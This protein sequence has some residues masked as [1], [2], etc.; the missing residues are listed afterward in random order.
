MDKEKKGSS[1]GAVGA[2]MAAGGFLGANIGIAGFFGAI[3]GA[4]PLALLGGYVGHRLYKA[5]TSEPENDTLGKPAE[6]DAA[7]IFTA[8]IAEGYREGL[9]AARREERMRAWRLANPP[10]PL[11]LPSRRKKP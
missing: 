2:G 1:S 10:P 4:V 9:E 8:G 3:S 7:E 6:A 11:V 5:T